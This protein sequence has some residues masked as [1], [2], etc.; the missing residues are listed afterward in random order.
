VEHPWEN[1]FAER[2]FQT[3][4]SLSRSLLKHADLPDRI[5]GKAILHSAYLMN[6]SPSSALGGIAPL[7]FRS[8]E[9]I[10]LSH[11]RVFG[12]PAQIF[13]RSTIRNDNKLS[14]RS[15]SGT[16]VGVSDKGNGYIFLIKKSNALVKVDSK[17][18]VEIDS[19]D[20]KFN[21]TFSDYRE[22][23]GKL[24]TAPLIDA[25]LRVIDDISPMN[26]SSKIDKDAQQDITTV[27]PHQRKITPRQFLLPGTHQHKEIE[28]RKQHYSN[29]CMENLMEDDN[30]AVF[31]LNCMEA[32]IDDETKLMK[33]LELLTACATSDDLSVIL[34]FM[35]NDN[36]VNLTIPDPKSQSDIDK[37]NPKDAKRFNDATITEVNGMKGKQVFVNATIDE[38]PPGTTVY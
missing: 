10:D 33:E 28:V 24:T 8:K 6:R 36:E 17:T 2:S 26:D 14:D 20:A 9:P 30:A 29:I 19:K 15:V 13:V 3:L 16:F 31:L 25:D 27:S 22:R 11:L 32:T 5:W 38:L 21:E 1:G 37:M 7:Q 12:S 23:Q 4:F 18:L 35:E 34:P